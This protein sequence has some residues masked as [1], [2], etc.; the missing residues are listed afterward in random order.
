M[1][2]DLAGC[3]IGW[4]RD[5]YQVSGMPFG[6]RG[7]RAD[8]YLQILKKIW[9]DDVVEFRGQFYNIPA[10][11]IGPKPIQKPHIPIYLGGYSL[12]T[13]VRMANYANGW[14]CVIRNSLD[15]A[16]SNIYKL[17]NECRKAKRDPKDIHIAAI[18]YPN[19]IDSGIPDKER[20]RIQ[21]QRHLLSG[22]VDQV[23]KDL[24]E[25]ERIGVDHLILNYNRSV[26]SDNTDKIIEVSKQ[27]SSFI[28]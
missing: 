12:S 2:L 13:F 23:G 21:P 10:S 6:N 19:V 20:H 28:R 27:L 14:I 3:G 11:K 4:S 24:Q 18:L 9:T 26:I 22:S 16:K 7:K 5:E 15:E 17:R 8:E 1:T 25:I